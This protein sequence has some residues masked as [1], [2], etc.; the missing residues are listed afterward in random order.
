[1][2]NK[3]HNIHKAIFL[4]AF[5][6]LNYLAIYLLT[7]SA[8][9]RDLSPFPRDIFMYVNSLVGD[10]GFF[11]IFLALAILIFK[12]DYYRAKF[13]MYITIAFSL[14]YLGISMY[15]KYY[16]MFFSFYNLSTFSS[17]GG[18]DAFGFLLSSFMSLLKRAEFFFLLPAVVMIV[19][20]ILSLLKIKR[21][22]NFGNHL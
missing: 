7:S 16:G 8:L 17:V 10:F 11:L 22:K 3:K 6:V 5:F 1:M 9:L 18:G 14:L 2:A 19:L 21:I 13:I 12:T 4:S 15:F 20:F